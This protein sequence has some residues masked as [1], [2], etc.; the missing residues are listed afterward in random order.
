MSVGLPTLDK[1][2][3]PCCDAACTPSSRG[4]AAISLLPARAPTRS[5]L[6]PGSAAP[7]LATQLGPLSG[8]SHALA[9]DLLDKGVEII[10]PVMIRDLVARLDV[11]DRA[12]LDHVFDEIDLRVW[13][14]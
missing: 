7:R 1:S 2:V 6:P 4:R 11:L 9:A 8:A 10:A 14:A 3:F 5:P 13:P 12:D